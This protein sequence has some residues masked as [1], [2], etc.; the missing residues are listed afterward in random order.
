[1]KLVSRSINHSLL[2]VTL[3][4]E[5]PDL[6]VIDY[7]LTCKP[8]F[9]NLLTLGYNIAG[10][11]VRISKPV[12]LKDSSVAQTLGEMHNFILPSE[13][14]MWNTEYIYKYSMKFRAY[15]KILLLIYVCKFIF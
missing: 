6:M 8:L 3:I 1:M 4:R 9:P 14:S 5:N 7:A 12:R 10:I 2:S 11:Q 13:Y 15:R